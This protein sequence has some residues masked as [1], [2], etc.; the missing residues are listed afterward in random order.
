VYDCIILDVMLPGTDGFSILAEIRE[1]KQVP[2]IM[3]TAK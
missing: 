1:T 3:T 2:V